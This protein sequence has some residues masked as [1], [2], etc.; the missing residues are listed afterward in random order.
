MSNIII[1]THYITGESMGEGWSNWRE[2]ADAL[3]TY[4]EANLPGMVADEGDTV[5]FEVEVTNN[6]GCVNNPCAYV[7]VDDEESEA[8]SFRVQ[9][10]KE[11]LWERF[12]NEFASTYAA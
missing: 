4:M 10:A 12:C 1:P 2:A 7:T 6:S 11:Q 5:E 9:T 8:M 3:A